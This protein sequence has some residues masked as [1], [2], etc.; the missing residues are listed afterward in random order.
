[1]LASDF[2]DKYCFII[3]AALTNVQELILC[4]LV[5][6]HHEVLWDDL[7]PVT[8]YTHCW[9]NIIRD[10]RTQTSLFQLSRTSVRSFWLKLRDQSG[11]SSLYLQKFYERGKIYHK[12]FLAAVILVSIVIYVTRH[13]CD[14]QYFSS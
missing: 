13:A 7:S 2:F 11:F 6:G 8:D 12:I 4:Q 5:A 1:M 10:F 3:M 14:M 9:E